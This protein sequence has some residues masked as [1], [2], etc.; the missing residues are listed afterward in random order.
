M[1]HRGPRRQQMV[2]GEAARA[3]ISTRQMRYG[4]RRA[5]RRRGRSA[6][7]VGDVQRGQS[8]RRQRGSGAWTGGRNT[9]RTA[10]DAR[11]T[12]RR[13]KRKG[14][15]GGRK[16]GVGGGGRVAG[17]GGETQVKQRNAKMGTQS[18]NAT[19]GMHK[20]RTQPLPESNYRYVIS[21]NPFRNAATYK[22]NAM[23]FGKEL[24]ERNLIPETSSGT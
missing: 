2:E 15:R 19:I 11:R 24:S 3:R 16:T 20:P 1:R 7:G 10:A 4:L 5:C 18:W 14:P 8:G 12:L 22:E 23:L 13:R 21:I 17:R 9:K 6:K